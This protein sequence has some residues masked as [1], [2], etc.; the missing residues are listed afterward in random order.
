MLYD[1]AS[2]ETLDG[3]VV[4]AGTIGTFVNDECMKEFLGKYEIPILTI[5]RKIGDYQC[6]RFSADGIGGIVNHLV[7]VHGCKRIAFVSGPRDNED[8]KQRL[9]A[10]MEAL[11]E[12]K[13]DIDEN[14]ITYGNFSEYSVEVVDELLDTCGELPEAICFA[15]DTMCV[16]AYKSLEK[17]GLIPGTDILITGYDDSP[18]ALSLNPML[19]TVKANADVLGYKSVEALYGMITENKAID[20]DMKSTLVFRNSC[21]C[22]IDSMISG[23]ELVKISNGLSDLEIGSLFVERFTSATLG[24]KSIKFHSDTARLLGE[25]FGYC[26]GCT[27]NGTETDIIHKLD[28]LLCRGVLD[29]LH[30]DEFIGLLDISQRYVKSKYP[31]NKSADFFLK[32]YRAIL[33]YSMQISHSLS[34]KQVSANFF[35]SNISKDMMMYSNNE[36]KCFHSIVHKL[37]KIDMRSSFLYIYEKP[38]NHTL[39]SEWNMPERM[40]LASYH[41]GKKVTVL[42]EI[43]RTLPWTDF[44]ENKFTPDIA[45]TMVVSVL[46]SNETQYGILVTDLERRYFPYIYSVIPQVGTAIMLISMVKYLR[47]SLEAANDTNIKLNEMSMCDELTGVYNR[48]GFYHYAN[49]EIQSKRNDGM[50]G[51]LIFAD[52]DNLKEIND[53]LGHDEGD[54]AIRSTAGYLTEALRHSD[55]VARTGGDEFAALAI[56]KSGDMAEKLFEKIKNVAKNHNR[57]SDK[58][59]NVTVSL[60]VHAFECGKDASIQD[61]MDIADSALYE[62]KKKKNKNIWKT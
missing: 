6:L 25:I 19:T 12:N 7:K 48:R 37:S 10:Y 61:Y 17:R 60:G 34:A 41:V 28:N 38:I 29:E 32:I 9:N 44:I 27:S 43:E 21:G 14:L 40:M 31:E 30:Y 59:Y 16:G 39:S 22:T 20:D 42:S 18:V 1:F 46:F 62:D 55:I 33:D 57:L 24:K 3:L 36:G 4:S 53:R 47:G 56:T 54:Y 11:T 50:I 15:N 26:S 13:I 58:K 52:V 23:E 49:E 8:A 5:E 45:R 2:K 35:I 51:I